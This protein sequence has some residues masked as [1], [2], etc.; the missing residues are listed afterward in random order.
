MSFDD[1]GAWIGPRDW[2]SVLLFVRDAG[3]QFVG[4]A[5]TVLG[6]FFVA[7][8]IFERDLNQR[9]A[10]DQKRFDEQ[11]NREEIESINKLYLTLWE[12]SLNIGYLRTAPPYILLR[13]ENLDQTVLQFGT[14]DQK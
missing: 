12:I 5:V 7:K 6:S 4:S 1:L 11:K 8:K 10:D 13:R 3:V 9:R 2:N 14:M